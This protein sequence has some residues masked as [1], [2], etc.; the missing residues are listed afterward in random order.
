MIR[1]IINVASAELVLKEHVGKPTLEKNG[2]RLTGEKSISI[3]REKKHLQ[4]K[5][6]LA[7]ID[8]LPQLFSLNFQ[9]PQ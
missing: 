5:N 4:S 6:W 1:Q 8:G 3:F 9:S 2:I 7:P